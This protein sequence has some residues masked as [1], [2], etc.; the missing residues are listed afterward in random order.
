MPTA[1]VTS[2]GQITVPVSV[3]RE[4][5]V[6]SGDLLAFEVKAGYVTVRRQ[7]SLEEASAKI[8]ELT[9]G[10]VPAY[11]DDDEAIL[12]AFGDAARAD[13]GDDLALIRVSDEDLA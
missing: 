11:A 9:R 12:S 6:K 1:K 8:R 10:S 3:R 13:R 4:L 5:G 2:K 7:D